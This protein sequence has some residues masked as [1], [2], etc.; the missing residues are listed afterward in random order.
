MTTTQGD[1]A[2][3]S[4]YVFRAPRWWTSAVFA[5]AIAGVAGAAAFASAYLLE[6]A[7]RGVL[8]IG[9]PTLIAAIATTPI[10]RVLG[11][12]LTVNRSMLLAV[13]CEFVLVGALLA[14]GLLRAIGLGP[15]VVREAL[16]AGVALVF[17]VRLVVL[18]AVSQRTNLAAIPASVQTVA[19]APFLAVYSGT[20]SV[21]AAIMPTDQADVAVA[22]LVAFTPMDFAMLAVASAVFG[23]ASYGFIRL[24]DRPWRRALGV[25][26]LDFVRGFVG[27]IAAGSQEL[28][29]F[30]AA[31]GE[32]AIVPVTVLAARRRD[33]GT[34]KA[35]FVLPM[36]HPGPMGEIGGGN[37][38]RRVAEISD[39]VG[40]PPHATAGH[41]FNLVSRA[42]VETLVAAANRAHDAV[43]YHRTAT[44]SVVTSVGDATITG[45][46][47]GEDALLV[48][49]YA[50]GFADDVEYGVGLAATAE[51]RA[52]GLEDVLLV[53]A[54][55]SNNGLE[56]EDL[57]HVSTGSPRAV[58]TL[59]AANEAGTAL[60]A[61][62][63]DDLS[64]GV[65]WTP[66]E[67]TPGEGIGP[68]GVR[69][70]VTEVG[71]DRT[72]YVLIDGNNMVPGLRDRL[73]DA[74]EA[75]D[76]AEIMT[77]DTHVVNTVQSTN[78]VG[79]A[80]DH[81]ALESVVTDLV[82]DAID[83]VEPVEAGV[84]TANAEVTVFGTDRTETLASH[85][86]AV[87]AM[88]GGL[89]VA[90]G[91]LALVVTTIILALV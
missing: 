83:D 6:D 40:F 88:G 41:D 72:A 53:D 10:D 13:T 90:L 70:A 58:D 75:V 19:T 46:R 11:G 8:F 37:L 59:A 74:L 16:L 82:A 29:A 35:R 61:A 12:Q 57:G 47:F 81:A 91:L 56:G 77:T 67:W 54:H 79:E 64:M 26:V 7:I 39:G 24:I 14:G 87:V 21:G 48:T 73:L 5:V 25:S 17:A 50:P 44:P 20:L 49:S 51:A 36:I 78:Q 30:F 22:P 43:T 38:P 71:D 2:A 32:D 89:A 86:N 33:D 3:L 84:G 65:A 85:A 15:T 45:Q 60:A 31:I 52:A 1:L 28:E 55:N 76:H 66:T 34:E 9:V 68:L 63:T 80:I 62:A 4:K 69:V 42:E 23:T 27:H 18:L